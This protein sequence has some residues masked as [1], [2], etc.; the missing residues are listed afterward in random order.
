MKGV[1]TSLSLLGVLCDIVGGDAAE[2]VDVV[3]GVKLGHVVGR[4]L[5]W[6]AHVHVL[7]QTVVLDQAMR[8]VY[9]V[10]F[11]WV[12]LPIVVAPHIRFIRRRRRRRIDR[13]RDRERERERER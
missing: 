6:L 10:R 4:G 3:I 9:P 1:H 5:R 8:H 13:Q 7:V 11:H 2:E 12:T